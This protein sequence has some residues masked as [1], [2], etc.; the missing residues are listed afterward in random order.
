ML[1]DNLIKQRQRDEKTYDKHNKPNVHRTK[2]QHKNP[3]NLPP[4]HQ[5]LW[6]TNRTHHRRTNT[7]SRPRRNTKHQMEKHTDTPM[8]TRIPRPPIP[9]IQHQHSPT[10]PHSNTHNLQ[11]PR[12]NNTNTTIL[13]YK[14][15][16]TN[17]T[18]QL[19]WPTRPRTTNR[20]PN[21]KHTI[22]KKHNSTNV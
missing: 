8:V 7:N 12:N 10:I 16:T 6:N 20:M 9:Q 1:S 18:H 2:Q 13:Q 4:Q 21:N 22:S 19:Q 14:R 5:I 11:T 3:R 15:L 17:T